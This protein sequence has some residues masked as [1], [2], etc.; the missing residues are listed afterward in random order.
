M[1][2]NPELYTDRDFCV[3]CKYAP[4]PGTVKNTLQ[5]NGVRQF[6]SNLMLRKTS[7]TQSEWNTW[8]N[9]C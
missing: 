4:Q 3:E 7:I 1:E 9:K 5:F 8:H 6:V 2:H